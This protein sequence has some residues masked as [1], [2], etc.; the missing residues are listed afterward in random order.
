M[1]WLG[2]VRERLPLLLRAPTRD[3]GSWWDGVQLTR[4]LGLTLSWTQERGTHHT[5]EHRLCRFVLNRSWW[6]PWT[7]QLPGS[8]SAWRFSVS[9]LKL[10]QQGGSSWHSQMWKWV[11]YRWGGWGKEVEWRPVQKLKGVGVTESV[12]T[13]LGDRRVASLSPRWTRYGVWIGTWKCASSPPGHS[14]VPLIKSP[15]T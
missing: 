1:S 7:S 10:Y 9:T 8:G 2:C 13:L 3:R 11:V 14:E 6:C 4:A 5:L 12:G 15:N